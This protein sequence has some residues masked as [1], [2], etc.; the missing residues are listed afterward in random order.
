MKLLWFHELVVTK[1][2]PV[3]GNQ[4]SPVCVG[5]IPR[6]RR[7]PSGRG[8]VHS[9]AEVAEEAVG[10]VRLFVPAWSTGKL[11][12][13]P[14]CCRHVVSAQWASPGWAT[15]KHTQYD[16]EDISYTAN[17]IKAV[18]LS[19]CR[20]SGEMGRVNISAIAVCVLFYSTF[21]NFI[22]P[23]VGNTTPA[24]EGW[25]DMQLVCIASGQVCWNT[26]AGAVFRWIIP[27]NICPFYCI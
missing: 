13:Q 11:H 2:K 8:W 7:V 3:S 22:R 16:F 19:F 20:V 26:V 9:G 6:P 10:G 4:H 17:L 21:F 1:M 23:S 24:I 18:S 27:Q 5:R 15:T 12:Q 25:S 14:E